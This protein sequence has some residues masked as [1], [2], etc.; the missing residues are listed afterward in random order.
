MDNKVIRISGMICNI[1]RQSNG[2]PV[3]GDNGVD[4][5]FTPDDIDLICALV[6]RKCKLVSDLVLDTRLNINEGWR[7]C[8]YIMHAWFYALREQEPYKMLKN[9]SDEKMA[10]LKEA[11]DI[12]KA[13]SKPTDNDLAVARQL[14]DGFVR[15]IK[16]EKN[17]NDIRKAQYNIVRFSSSITLTLGKDPNKW[18]Q[19]CEELN[20]WSD[21]IDER[22]AVASIAGVGKPQKPSLSIDT[23]QRYP[24][25]G[26]GGREIGEKPVH[27]QENTEVIGQPVSV[28]QTPVVEQPVQ[29]ERKPVVER[30]VAQNQP[31]EKPLSMPKE[32]NT[33]ESGI[34]HDDKGNELWSIEYLAKKMGYKDV[35][36]VYVKK[37]LYLKKHS[38]EDTRKFF[39][40]SFVYTHDGKKRAWFVAEYFEELKQ[41]IPPVNKNVRPDEIVKDKN[42]KELWKSEKLAK[43]LGFNSTEY[44]LTKKC[45]LRKQRPDIDKWFVRV[46]SAV[47]FYPEYFEDLKA[48]LQP[49]VTVREQVIKEEDNKELWSTAKIVAELG[50]PGE[51]CF[52]NRKSRLLKRNPE[53]ENYFV[54]KGNVVYFKAE[55]FDEFKKLLEEMGNRSYQSKGDI[56]DRPARKTGQ[57]RD[58]VVDEQHAVIEHG[59]GV[60]LQNSG[61][62]KVLGGIGSGEQPVQTVV[63]NDRKDEDQAPD[64]LLV[65]SPKDLVEITSLQTFVTKLQDLFDQQKQ[66]EQTAKAAYEAAQKRTA[67]IRNLLD[68]VAFAEKNLRFAQ[69]Y[70]DRTQAELNQFLSDNNLLER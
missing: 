57:K 21:Y 19:V 23:I 55:N 48:L 34:I 68:D 62:D 3:F 4:K 69:M 45:E 30:V 32:N 8:D 53:I 70:F 41:Y 20:R 60:V 66:T 52:F 51:M 18:A 36:S 10:V 65:E 29:I 61:G 54:R 40:K 63:E 24:G 15:R 67:D 35:N 37:T 27:N 16:D 44:F 13:R 14:I 22:V 9:V 17:I 47:Y 64:V 11:L 28:E 5:Y 49:L 12:A 56:S 25:L 7:Q 59:R 42:G 43:M 39:E 50:L 6:K 1:L 33:N 58:A 38:D 31:V 46:G 26:S 2:Q